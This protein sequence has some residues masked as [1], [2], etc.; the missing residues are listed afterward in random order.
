M[1]LEDLE[2]DVRQ[3]EQDMEEMIPQKKAAAAKLFLDKF[4][5]LALIMLGSL[6]AFHFFIPVNEKLALAVNYMNIAVLL[7][8]GA[9][10][11]LSFLLADSH[12]KFLREHWFDALLVL[13]AFA[14]VKDARLLMTLESRTEEKAVLGFVF[15]R[16]TT[17]AGQVTKMYTWV[18]RILNF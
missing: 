7:F 5:P 17:L 3:L 12:K 14:L 13:P 11:G 8:F 10:L 2:E 1:G 15:A 16:S 9:R 4:M 6:I 18:R